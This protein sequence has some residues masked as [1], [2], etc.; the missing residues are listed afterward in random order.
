MGLDGL[1]TLTEDERT[2]FIAFTSGAFRFYEASRLQWRH[3]QL[4]AEHWQNVEAFVKDIA[5]RAGIADFWALRRHMHS[6]EF[7]TWF[8]SL[9]RAA[10]AAGFYDLPINRRPG[11]RT[12]LRRTGSAASVASGPPSLDRSDQLTA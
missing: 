8:E 1:A 9:P 5:N 11:L 12:D 6:S 3:G 4:H 2:R 10:P 7:R